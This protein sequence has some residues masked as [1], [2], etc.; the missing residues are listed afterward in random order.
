MLAIQPGSRV[1][2]VG[3]GTGA[4]AG[5]LAARGARIWGIDP[6]PRMREACTRA[7]PG[8]SVAAGTFTAIPHADVAF[9]LAISSFAFH[10]VP[11]SE[12]PAAGAEV[13]RVLKPGGSLC[14]L[15]IMF[16]SPAARDGARRRIGGAWDDD[17]DYPL[18]A[19]LDLTLREAGF[20]PLRWRQTADCHWLVLAGRTPMKGRRR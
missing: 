9:D 10:E 18:V 20:A 19:D 12:R 16:A 5:L 3:I 13:L 6:S 11:V 2:D 1:L 8:F 17:E 14:L 15:D 4:F 7:H